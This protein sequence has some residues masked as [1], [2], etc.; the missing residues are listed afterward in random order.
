MTLA[1]PLL[2]SCCAN[3]LRSKISAAALMSST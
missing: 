3:S 2:R 1:T